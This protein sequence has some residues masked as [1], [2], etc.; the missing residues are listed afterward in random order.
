M[1]A[2]EDRA[3]RVAEASAP[4]LLLISFVKTFSGTSGSF[5]VGFSAPEETDFAEEVFAFL[6]GGAG[7]KLL[8][9]MLRKK[10]NSSAHNQDLMREQRQRR[11][12]LVDRCSRTLSMTRK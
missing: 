2:K 12:T 8:G 4:L 3:S 9:I 5:S 6:G 1:G 11:H 10:K 7:G